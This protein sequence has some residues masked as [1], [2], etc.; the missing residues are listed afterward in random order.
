MKYLK[1]LGLAAA[2]AVAITAFL[3]AGSASA[4]VLCK[5]TTTPCGAGN[6][7][8]GALTTSLAANTKTTFKVGETIISEC[9]GSELGGKV[10]NAGGASK[11]VVFG[12]SLLLFTGCSKTTWVIRNTATLNVNHISGTDNGAIEGKGELT[13]TIKVGGE[14]ECN[15]VLSSSFVNFGN[16]TGGKQAAIAL[17][18]T[19]KKWSIWEFSCPG[20]VT[21]EGSYTVSSPASTTLHSQAE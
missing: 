16:F 3:G 14:T 6:I 2:A 13:V 19:L 5:V 8:S 9:T 10:E 17:E 4:T 7:Y 20:E 12:T 21:W 1:T 11:P 18:T 15:F